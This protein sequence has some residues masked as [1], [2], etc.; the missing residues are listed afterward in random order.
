VKADFDLPDDLRMLRDTLR[1]F[2]D[3]ELI[4]HD[5]RSHMFTEATPEIM[6]SALSDET[7]GVT[8]G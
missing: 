8:N 2:V 1:R 6:C 3:E 7:Q 5:Q 4:R